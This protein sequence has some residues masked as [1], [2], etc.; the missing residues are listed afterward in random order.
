[1]ASYP[2]WIALLGYRDWSLP[3]GCR[4][5]A[6]LGAGSGRVLISQV[7]DSGSGTVVHEVSEMK[8]GGLGFIVSHISNSRCGPP[9]ERRTLSVSAAEFPPK[10]RQFFKRLLAFWGVFR[11]IPLCLFAKL[12]RISIIFSGSCRRIRRTN[13]ES[14]PQ[15]VG[16]GLGG[17][18]GLRDYGLW[19]LGPGKS[20]RLASGSTFFHPNMIVRAGREIICNRHLRWGDLPS[21]RAAFGWRVEVRGIASVNSG[22]WTEKRRLGF[23]VSYP[24]GDETAEWMGHQWL[25][26]D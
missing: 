17:T 14:D 8:S 4:R 5:D 7:R 6:D 12:R 20:L 10:N 3:V 16:G 15:G 25:N 9:A 22:Q 26:E 23:L 13:G 24:F 2:V 18:E 11:D 1:M 19:D 21:R